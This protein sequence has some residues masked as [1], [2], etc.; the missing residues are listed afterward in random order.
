[1]KHFLFGFFPFL[2]IF[3]LLAFRGS[4]SSRS[5]CALRRSFP[6][7]AVFPALRPARGRL[8]RIFRRFY[9]ILLSCFGLAAS[10]FTAAS[11]LGISLTAAETAR[12][13]WRRKS[14][15]AIRNHHQQGQTHPHFFYHFFP[16][17][18]HFHE[19]NRSSSAGTSWAPSVRPAR[20]ADD[21]GL[22]HKQSL[23]KALKSLPA[24]N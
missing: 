20:P 17:L 19:I 9:R 8:L 12:S 16:P 4:C 15:T 5:F 11:V 7:Y 13:S 1:M 3:S 21:A 22:F 18:L 23:H 10:V 24:S 6:V 14:S 2:F